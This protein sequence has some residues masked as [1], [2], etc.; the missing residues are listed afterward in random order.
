[1][2][3]WTRGDHNTRRHPS[4]QR[5]TSS[6]TPYTHPLLYMTS[7]SFSPFRP[8]MHQSS[9]DRLLIRRLRWR[10][11]LGRSLDPSLLSPSSSFVRRPSLHGF[12][13]SCDD[14]LARAAGDRASRNFRMRRKESVVIGIRASEGAMHSRKTSDSKPN[15]GCAYGHGR[16]QKKWRKGE[17]ALSGCSWV[18]APAPAPDIKMANITKWATISRTR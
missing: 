17:V 12:L 3:R 16:L 11:P 4:R 14:R 15:I 5:P 7:L 8:P 18:P 10:S 13:H 2:T 6:A 1:M 9:P